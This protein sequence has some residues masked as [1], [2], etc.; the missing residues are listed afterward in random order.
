MS[1][2]SDN[3]TK[4]ISPT[5]R[6]GSR[7]AVGSPPRLAAARRPARFRPAA[8]LGRRLERLARERSRAK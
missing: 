4:D 1:L 3:D 6:H 5:A 2:V 8:L 7:F